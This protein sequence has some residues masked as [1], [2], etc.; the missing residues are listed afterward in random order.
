MN[1]F[2]SVKKN[3]AINDSNSIDSTFYIEEEVYFNKT[4]KFYHKAKCSAT[5]PKNP[6]KLK[7][8]K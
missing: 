2:N 6:I 3:S 1:D 8:A 5:L 7:E 4:S